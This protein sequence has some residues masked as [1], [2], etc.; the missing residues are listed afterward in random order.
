MGRG[1]RSRPSRAALL[2]VVAGSVGLLAAHAPRSHTSRT[3]GAG[4]RLAGAGTSSRTGGRRVSPA[5]V[6]AAAT[7]AAVTAIT[8][9]TSAQ[10]PGADLREPADARTLVAEPVRVQRATSP[11][12]HYPALRDGPDRPLLVVR[13]P[14]S[15]AE[16][17]SRLRWV[18]LERFDGRIWT[19]AAEYQRAGRSL[20]PGPVL[21]GDSDVTVAEV[22]LRDTSLAPWLPTVGRAT[23]VSEA[24]LGVDPR[25]GDLV[26]PVG[27]PVPST[28]TVTGT[29][30]RLDPGLLRGAVAAPAPAGA[31]E[32]D[33]PPALVE[34][35][36][37]ATAGTTTAFGRLAGLESLFR[38]DGRF[39]LARRRRLGPAGRARSVPAVA[40]A[41]GT[42]RH[43]GAVR[44][45]VR[46]DGA[47]PRL[48]QPG[49]SSGSGPAVT[50]TSA[51]TS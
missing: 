34:A 12:V 22:E 5:A 50:Q 26:V 1:G 8:V 46:R 7:V 35:T 2:L 29:T 21:T 23:K 37:R 49:W 48:R 6:A 13:T 41:G 44:Q 11:L 45:R 30:P 9:L 24:G 42:R 31:D 28:Y 47:D 38:R 27:D 36:Q 33:V 40:A 16:G 18:T 25:A 20:P 39:T 43:R 15:D 4:P 19:T 10:L 51:A 3:S 32:Y 17:L 14:R